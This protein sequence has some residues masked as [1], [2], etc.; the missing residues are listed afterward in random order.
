MVFDFIVE[1]DTSFLQDEARQLVARES[2]E[3]E[4]GTGMLI[5]SKIKF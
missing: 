4:R 2:V 5:D 3:P 1:V